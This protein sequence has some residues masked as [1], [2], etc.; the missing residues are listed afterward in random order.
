MAI[1]RSL[2]YLY[3]YSFRKTQPK[4]VPKKLDSQGNLSEQ[5]FNEKDPMPRSSL[6]S[7]HPV[8]VTSIVEMPQCL[9]HH[10]PSSFAVRVAHK[11]EREREEL[12]SDRTVETTDLPDGVALRELER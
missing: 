5:N 11:R 6:E 4:T 9:L 3:Y 2:S 12:W 7:T 1:S 10:A 8:P